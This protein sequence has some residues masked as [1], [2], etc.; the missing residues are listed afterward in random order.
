[1]SIRVVRPVWVYLVAGVY[2]T[3]LLA[4][5]LPVTHLWEYLLFGTWP[6]RLDG[7]LWPLPVWLVFVTVL[8]L[9]GLSLLVIPIGH[10]RRRPA[11]KASTVFTVAGSSLAAAVLAFGAG[12]SLITLATVPPLRGTTAETL[13]A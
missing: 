9:L 2:V 4:L 13:A 5:L 3:G 8:L 10:V 12:L 11:G 7:N 6:N 1:L